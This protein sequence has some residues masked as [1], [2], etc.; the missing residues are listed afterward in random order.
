LS[1][2]PV[3]TPARYREPCPKS[4]PG[5]W[6]A[7]GEDGATWLEVHAGGGEIGRSGLFQ[8]RPV[9]AAELVEALRIAARVAAVEDLGD[10]GPASWQ[11]RAAP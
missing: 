11:R 6:L 3:P 5:L 4:A 1:R 10:V 7:E 9:T 8:S 2:L